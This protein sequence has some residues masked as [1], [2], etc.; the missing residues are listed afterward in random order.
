MN[1]I[2]KILQQA[3]EKALIT[4]PI[5]YKEI[6]YFKIDTKTKDF[7]S[8]NLSHSSPKYK[9]VIHNLIKENKD[10]LL[11]ITIYGTYDINGWY[12]YIEATIDIKLLKYANY[13]KSFILLELAPYKEQIAI[14]YKEKSI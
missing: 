4:K 2:E 6:E 9:I 14:M 7:L 13:S 1:K 5:R 11:N 12:P 8:N 10:T 3:I